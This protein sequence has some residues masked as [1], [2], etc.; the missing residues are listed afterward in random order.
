MLNRR[1]MSYIVG[2]CVAGLLFVCYISYREYE[3]HVAFER[4]ISDTEAFSRSV[5][6]PE[7]DGHTHLTDT[8]PHGGENPDLNTA[9]DTTNP[10]YK[11][12]Q[13]D[14]YAYMAGGKYVYSVVP[15]DR[16]YLELYAW[17][18]TGEKTPYVEKHLKR[19]AENSPYKGQVVQ[20]IVTPDGQLHNVIVP[21][22]RQ[23][24]EG[25]V[26]LQSELDPP[27]LEA[28]EQDQRPA[29]VEIAGEPIPDEYYTI[30]DPYERHEFIKK[31]MFS[32]QLKIS[33]AA[34]EAKIAKGEIDVS[35]SAREK[36]TVDN[37]EAMKERERMLKSFAKPIPSDKPPVK[38]SFLSDAAEDTLPGWMR[39]LEGTLPSGS[40]ETEF[41]GDYSATDPFSE[42]SINEDASGA[43]VRSDVPV[44]PSDLPDIVK[45]I[46]PQSV[47]DLEKQLTPQGIG[48]DLIEGLSTN[49]ADKAKQLIEQY[50]TEEGL[51]RLRESDPDAARQFERGH[52]RSEK[53]RPSEPSRDAPDGEESER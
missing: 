45:P 14:E 8:H 44:S 21:H 36:E 53:L 35:L 39:K 22:D 11:G 37:N 29:R 33:M 17:E 10:Y 26:I 9:V 30:E 31:V 13:G 46:S 19:L 7:T 51:R 34:L 32:K 16:E 5:E 27:I 3:K 1:F 49:P 50:G 48:S 38:V 15:L 4:F 20:R 25:D 43:P 6:H 41:G 42:G 24:E 12:K 52:P 47:A 40:S 28:L 23:Y 2:V 18:I